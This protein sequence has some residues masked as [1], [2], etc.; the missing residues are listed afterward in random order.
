MNLNKIWLS[1]PHMGLNEITNVNDAFTSNWNNL[2]RQSLE[3][4]WW[5]L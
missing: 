4:N 5:E 1:S 2:L 3:K